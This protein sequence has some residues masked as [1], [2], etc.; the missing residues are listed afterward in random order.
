[1][2]ILLD[3]PP[4][5]HNGSKQEKLSSDFLG[6]PVRRQGRVV[7]TQVGGL[8]RWLTE[9]EIQECGIV[10]L[11][12]EEEDLFERDVKQRWT[13]NDVAGVAP[14]ACADEVRVPRKG[15][16]DGNLHVSARWASMAAA[17]D[18]RL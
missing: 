18:V 12:D 6:P 7:G 3:A 17:V 5:P 2:T 1:M 15:R 16:S 11:D 8:E 10:G 13:D 14:D 9:D 4:S